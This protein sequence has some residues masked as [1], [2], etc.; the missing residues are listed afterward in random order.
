MSPSKPATVRS[1]CGCWEGW[2]DACQLLEALANMENS[3]QGLALSE[4]IAVGSAR[5]H[6]SRASWFETRGVATLLTMRV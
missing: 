3:K 6:A 2:R 5:D 1:Q 4:Q